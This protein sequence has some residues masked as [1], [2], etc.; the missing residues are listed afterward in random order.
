MRDNSNGETDSSSNSV[1]ES[2]GNYS[3]KN[4]SKA[5]H[6]SKTGGHNDSGFGK[7]F[8]V[9]CVSGF[10][11]DLN[12]TCEDGFDP[13]LNVSSDS[14]CSSDNLG[15]GDHKMKIGD[16]NVSGFG[17]N[18][19]V[20]C[21]SGFET[22]FNVSCDA[23]FGTNFNVSSI[24]AENSQDGNES[25]GTIEE[26]IKISSTADGGYSQDTNSCTSVAE[27]ISQHGGK[28]GIV[29]DN[30]GVSNIC[31]KLNMNRASI[32]TDKSL[33]IS[34]LIQKGVIDEANL[35]VSSI[36]VDNKVKVVTSLKSQ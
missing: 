3:S 17:T 14:C 29:G 15:T 7:N 24:A 5:E 8:N 9:S 11:M 18:L 1:S 22:N 35:H 31:H 19:N 13:N 10:D 21:V 6:V 26:E 33:D 16:L 12:V 30:Q 2:N 34:S 27:D 28:I 20:T 36:S 4:S 32:E 25:M 23:G